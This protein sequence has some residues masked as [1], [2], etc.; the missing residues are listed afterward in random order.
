MK[1]TFRLFLI[2]VSVS[3]L[4]IVSFGLSINVTT[5]LPCDCSGE[6]IKIG[7]FDVINTEKNAQNFLNEWKKSKYK[8]AF[9]SLYDNKK[10]ISFCF[11]KDSNGVDFENNNIKFKNLENNSFNILHF[12]YDVQKKMWINN[13]GISCHG[14]TKDVV[15][16]NYIGLIAFDDMGYNGVPIQCYMAGNENKSFELVFNDDAEEPEK[17]NGILGFIKDFFKNLGDFFIKIVVPPKDYFKN[18]FSEIQMAVNGKFKALTDL[19]TIL[20]NFG[21]LEVEGEVS[22]LWHIPDNYIYQGF[23]GFDVDILQGAKPYLIF[24]RPVLTAVVVLM[25]A[26]TCYKKLASIM[27]RN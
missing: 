4:T 1:K 23:K 7:A 20:C 11:L 14:A 21:K 2:V 5:S 24:L 10:T 17:D 13:N 15:A 6:T 25:T 18:F 16:L 9:Y 22:S 8:I 3:V 26:I 12:Y 19:Y 27:E